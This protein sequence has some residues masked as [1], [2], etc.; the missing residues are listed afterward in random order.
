MLS[1]MGSFVHMLHHRNYFTAKRSA[2]YAENTLLPFI[3]S[4]TLSPVPN[5]RYESVANTNILCE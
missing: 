5:I 3:H 2:S 1:L 4:V